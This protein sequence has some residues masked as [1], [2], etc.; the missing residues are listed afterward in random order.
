[1]SD[2]GNGKTRFPTIAEIREIN[3]R[4]RL[5]APRRPELAPEVPA[6]AEMI[7][8]LAHVRLQYHPLFLNAHDMPDHEGPRQYYGIDYR[9]VICKHI[10]PLGE[11][12]KD[13]RCEKCGLNYKY[14]RTTTWLWVWKDK[15]KLVIVK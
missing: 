15:P 3:E 6:W 13:H 11:P 2:E 12:G 10:Q 4:Q 14:T 8:I 1:M 7:N 9:C 5:S